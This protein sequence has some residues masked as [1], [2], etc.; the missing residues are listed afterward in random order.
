LLIIW[1]VA[2]RLTYF[3][4]RYPYN[5]HT[6]ASDALWAGVPVLTCCGATFA[7]RVAASLLRA[8]G[9]DELIA[10]SLESYETLAL[11]LAHDQ[12]YLASLKG[13]LERNRKTFPLFDTARTTRQIEAAYTMMWQSYQSGQTAA[14]RAPQKIF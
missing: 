4:I 10:H 1:R 5:A 9:L 12:A 14:P 7:G 11:K 3:S 13:K 6:T 8:I 2:H